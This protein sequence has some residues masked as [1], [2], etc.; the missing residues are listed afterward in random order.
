MRSRYISAP[1]R[2]KLPLWALRFAAAGACA[3]AIGA[4][5]QFCLFAD[6]PGTPLSSGH[7]FIS[8]TAGSNFKARRHHLYARTRPGEL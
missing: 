5:N 3:S 6:C 1:S 8:L 7:V 2:A 4:P